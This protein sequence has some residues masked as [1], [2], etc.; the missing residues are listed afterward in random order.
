MPAPQKIVPH[1]WFDKEKDRYGLSWQIVPAAM[2]EMM[3]TGSPDQI[4]RIMEAFLSTKKLDL[5][6][7]QN[8]YAAA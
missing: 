3:L 6:V 8:A 4:A 2:E 7:L 5:A 1:I